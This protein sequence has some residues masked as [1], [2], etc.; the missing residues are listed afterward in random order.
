MQD[1]LPT[2]YRLPMVSWSKDAVQEDGSMSDVRQ[3]EERLPNL[4]VGLGVWTADSSAG[5]CTE[6]EGQLAPE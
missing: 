3:V 5:Q 2:F 4:S 6:G 1:L